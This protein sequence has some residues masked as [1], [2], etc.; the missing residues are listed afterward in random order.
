MKAK[1]EQ[2]ADAHAEFVKLRSE[3]DKV[4]DA[5]M[6]TEDFVHVMRVHDD[7][8]FPGFFRTGWEAGVKA[9]QENYPEIDLAD[10]PTPEDPILLQQF[11]TQVHLTEEGDAAVPEASSARANIEDSDSSSSETGSE[12]EAQREDRDSMDADRSPKI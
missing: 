1:E 11:R 10:Y 12:S 2:L 8:V 4:I 7:D 5:Y 6:D 9:V 3:R